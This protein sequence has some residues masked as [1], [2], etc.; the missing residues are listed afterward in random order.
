MWTL[1]CLR[2]PP[3]AANNGKQCL[4]SVSSFVREYDT[5][6]QGYTPCPCSFR[7]IS[8]HYIGVGFGKA[9]LFFI[10]NLNNS[11][12]QLVFLITGYRWKEMVLKISFLHFLLAFSISWAQS[13][14]VWNVWKSPWIIC[15]LLYIIHP[16]ELHANKMLTEP[17]TKVTLLTIIM[18]HL[19]QNKHLVCL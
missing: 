12:C 4:T 3:I 11:P 15:T 17:L 6:I 1:K 18:L 16:C 2:K 5:K 19:T 10:L 7:Y 9:F 13:I 8:T 14:F